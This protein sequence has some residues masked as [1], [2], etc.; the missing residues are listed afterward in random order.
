MSRGP[1]RL[2]ADDLTGA[3]DA[4]VHFAP[5]GPASVRWRRPAGDAVA[6]CADVRDAPEAE[7]R[8]EV[9]EAAPWLG[10]A[11]VPF[12]KIDSRLRGH[13]ATTLAEAV[14]ALAPAR[15]V[16]CPAAPGLGR[17][18][19]AGRVWSLAADGSWECEPRAL[20]EELAALGLPARSVRAGEPAPAGASLWEAESEDDLAAVARAGLGAEGRTLW[21]G[22]TG[23]AQAVA[24]ALGASAAPQVAPPRPALGVVGTPHPVTL[25][26][27]V[28][29]AAR[30][31]K[32]VVE[33]G[34]YETGDA[35]AAAL[36]R[37]RSR[38]AR[39]VP[40]PG[41]RAAS[42]DAARAVAGLLG[43]CPRPAS[44]FVTG[45]A[46]LAFAA[47]AL[48]ARSLSLLGSLEPG[49]PVSRLEGGRWDGLPVLSKSGGF[50]R[51][52]LLAD[53]FAPRRPG[54]AAPD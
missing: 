3:L 28:R 36:R 33:I 51:P 24:R 6:L 8:R 37:G 39:A 43:G 48:E 18:V 11:G 14:A 5:L 22:A 47:E 10:E 21:V 41:S 38:L 35:V 29:L 45:G 9:G 15:A 2:L 42:A 27:V 53:L 49:A 44:L 46:T 52:D 32:T 13:V 40:S 34:P 54:A 19:R 7:A 20:L 17:V 16:I 50:G 1:A 12:L 30:A 26:Q 4:A 31:P 23:L 25:A